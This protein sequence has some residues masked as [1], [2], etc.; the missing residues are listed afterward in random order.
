MEFGVR[1]G[2]AA[3][4]RPPRDTR[5][6]LP[7]SSPFRGQPGGRHPRAFPTGS[8]GAGAPGKSQISL[9]GYAIILVVSLKSFRTRVSSCRPRF[10]RGSN[11]CNHTAPRKDYCM[12]FPIFIP[13]VRA[14]VRSI[15][16]SS[17][18]LT[19][20]ALF[21]SKSERGRGQ[22]VGGEEAKI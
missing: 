22:G 14:R 19:P 9:N 15:C 21:V 1:L 17:N 12:T 7:P 5:G 3:P 2:S 18:T 4:P 13:R 16:E 6:L 11:L 20:V 10:L 8:G